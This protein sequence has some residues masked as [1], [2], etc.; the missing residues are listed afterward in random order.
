LNDYQEKLMDAETVAFTGLGSYVISRAVKS[1]DLLMDR[2]RQGDCRTIYAGIQK[3]VAFIMSVHIAEVMQIFI[4]IISGIPVVRTPLQILFLILA[5]DLPP[6][7][8]LGMEPGDKDILRHAP[9]PRRSPWS[10]GGCG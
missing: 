10:S 3:F 8:A 6:S 5:T 9:A 1:P 2:N 4:H 7:I